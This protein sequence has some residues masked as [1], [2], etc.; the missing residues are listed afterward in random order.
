MKLAKSSRKVNIFAVTRAHFVTIKVEIPASLGAQSKSGAL[1]V[2]M[3]SGYS[4]RS[5]DITLGINLACVRVVASHRGLA[6]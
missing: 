6:T 2:S 4:L 1:Y 5:T 3:E